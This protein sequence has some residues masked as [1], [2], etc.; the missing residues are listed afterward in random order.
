M[1]PRVELRREPAADLTD[2]GSDEAILERIR[3][4]IRRDGPMPF[5]R[6]MELALYDAE[7][8]YYRGPAARPG[9][10]GD[11]LT[12]PELH[13]IFGASLAVALEDIWMRLGRPEP[14]VVREFGSGTGTLALAILD[15]LALARSPLRAAV[16]YEAVDVDP[17][18]VEALASRLTAAGHGDVLDAA[19][20]TAAI[21]GVVLANEVLD[22]LPVHRVR[23]RDGSLREIAIELDA[24]GGLREMEVEPSIPALAERLAAE[25]VELVEGQ[26]AE[27]GLAA[28]AW[29]A[30]AAGRLRRG[31][32]VLIDYGAPAAELF[33]PV[34]RR[35]GT[36]RAYVRHQVHDDPYRHVGR[37]DLTAHVDVTAVERAARAAGLT[38]VGI[39]TQAEALMGLGIEDRLRQVQADP[40][41]TFEDY[42]LV[43]AALMRLLDPAA[44]GR[45]RVMAFGRDW[46]ATPDDPPLR[47]FSFRLPAGRR[48]APG[49]R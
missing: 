35:D 36:L 33:D 47:M 22:A 25:G 16:R 48:A 27:V 2:V 40:A 39:T 10:A 11:F 34:R 9:R 19:D 37:Q 13:P 28:D 44:M 5:A 42:A 20:P 45:F 23:W 31:L 41:T 12:A 18:R 38:T 43:R 32:L 6:F 17:R 14:F 8:G 15:E 26:T 21:D 49:P 3:D 29:I 24:D 1:D 46:P 30:A 4:E 7:G